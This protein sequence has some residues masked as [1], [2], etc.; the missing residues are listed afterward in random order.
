[1]IIAFFLLFM[2]FCKDLTIVFSK[3]DKQKE[4]LRTCMYIY[5]EVNKNFVIGR[6]VWIDED[7]VKMICGLLHPNMKVLEYGS[8]G[9]TTLFG[10]FVSKWI[11]VE[12]DKKWG[13]LIEK[14]INGLNLQD[15]KIY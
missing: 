8:G 3:I 1:M 12:H 13:K 14:Y 5:K 4:I 2:M 10:S 9:S 15:Y 6:S 7:G 11:S